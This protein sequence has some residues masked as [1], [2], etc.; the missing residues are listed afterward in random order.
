MIHLFD[1]GRRYSVRVGHQE[2]LLDMMPTRDTVLL[3]GMKSS[4]VT[5]LSN[6]DNMQ[7]EATNN[8]YVVWTSFTE[9]DR[10]KADLVV[11]M[12]D[13]VQFFFNGRLVKRY[14]RISFIQYNPQ[15][16]AQENTD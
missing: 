2:L 7:M 10:F 4:P 15:W 3:L 12:L 8:I 11:S 5:T 13:E 1:Q 14:P 6:M 9:A 16:V